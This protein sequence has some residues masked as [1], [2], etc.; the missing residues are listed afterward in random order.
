MSVFNASE[1]FQFAIRIEEMGEKF[2][3]KM[4]QE[5]KAP[6]AQK[7]F[8]YLA[9]EETKH[10][11]TFTEM[12][13]KIE[14]YEPPESYPGEYFEYLRSYV[15][16]I[17]F[18]YKKIEKEISKITDAARALEFGIQIELDSILY[19]LEMKNFVP[20]R[21]HDIIDRIIEEERRHYLKLK[22][23]KKN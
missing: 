10:K 11:K 14:K 6:N 21:Q 23:F 13:S 20:D 18:S 19:Y 22:K 9:K 12:L 2:Y 3:G 7:L 1:I 16:D 17:I 8:D 5:L 4:A 15:D